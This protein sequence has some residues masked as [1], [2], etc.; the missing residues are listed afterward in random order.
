M[1]TSPPPRSTRTSPTSTSVAST[2]RRTPEPA[3]R[4]TARRFQKSRRWAALLCG[5]LLVASACGG[6]DA[7]S[8]PTPTPGV[9]TATPPPASSGG[10]QPAER[11]LVDLARRYR[12]LT[13]LSPT[14]ELPPPSVGDVL[15]FNVFHLSGNPDVPPD[16]VVVDA[17]LRA[18]SEHAYVFVEV[19]TG[20]PDDEVQAAV[21]ALEDDVW[22]V[23]VGAFGPPPNP[24]VDGDPRI[25][26]LHAGLGSAVGGYVSDSD[27][28]P[29]AVVP[30]S[31]QRDMVYLD[32]GVRPLGSPGY[33]DLLA[34]ELQHLIHRRLD[35]DES[36]WV[37]EG[38]SE[39][40]AAL[41]GGSRSYGSFLDRP[42]LPLT[43]WESIGESGAHYAASHL[44]M[45]YLLEQTSARPRR[46]AAEAG[47]S[48]QGV[49]AFLS[50]VDSDRSFA[51]IAAGWAVANFLDLP[52]GPYGYGEL[53]V[54][55]PATIILDGEGGESST[56]H[57]FG[58]DYFELA[59]GDF[60]GEPAFEFD[61]EVDVAYL[62]AQEEAG[63]AFWWSGRGDS[64]DATLTRDL[65]LTGV[66]EA[67]L[68]F[69]TW[70]DIERWY[71]FGYVAVSEDAGETWQA[72]AGRHTTTDDPTK[73][74]YGPG[75]SGESGDEPGWVD[76]R[77]DLT[78]FAG[79]RI[80][81]RFEYVTDAGLNRPGWA[82]DDIAV[83]VIGFIDDAERDVGGWHREGFRI[84]DERLPQRFELRLIK[85]TSPPGVEAI[86][87]DADNHARITLDGLGSEYQTAVVVVMAVTDGT[88]EPARYR[89]TVST[90]P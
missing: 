2:S 90:T 64:I 33:A 83:P 9:P 88:T 73:S 80:L 27:G 24:G 20:V 56:V 7:A 37:N 38:L 87:L 70:F 45:T 3:S 15:P 89:Y 40:A 34:H 62:A 74:S 32:I 72:L 48:V 54:S 67:T 18:I 60:A 52:S 77:I 6:G 25:V 76:E 69:R 39:V 1:P 81:L 21:R 84:L 59:A 46:L 16:S 5:A 22:P 82:I 43:S 79:S 47:N 35:P 63:G 85:M 14:V 44:F 61:G 66:S 10:N 58:A 4:R 8:T 50:A 41:V 11:D 68:T 49:E 29:R 28:Y 55:A 31:N 13:D 57:Q 42:D 53:E 78:P 86:E 51:E 19:G 23:V 75:Y 71:D 36:N 26:V 12:G 65:D 17:E 30:L